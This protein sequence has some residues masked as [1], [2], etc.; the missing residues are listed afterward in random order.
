MN[1]FQTF[2]KKVIP[3]STS[4]FFVFVFS[5]IFQIINEPKEIFGIPL[6]PIYHLKGFIMDLMM[7]LIISS[8]GMLL[9]LLLRI[10]IRK[11]NLFPFHLISIL[12]ILINYTLTVYF[13]Q[14]N[15]L[16]GDAFYQLT[17]SELIISANLDSNLTFLSVS[18][19]LL[20]II[21]YFLIA[22]L[23]KKFR[24]R[25]Y[26]F[27]VFFLLMISSLIAY[28]WKLIQSEDYVGDRVINNKLLA[29]VDVSEKH[30]FAKN[31]TESINSK[32]FRE[33]DDSFFPDPSTRNN[34]YSLIHEL[35]AESEF[36]NFIH[37]SPKGPPNIVIIIVESLS[38]FLVK[39]SAKNPCNVMPF[40]DSLSSKSLYF[41][42][43]ISSCERTHNV[44]PAILASSPN[45]PEKQFM[46]TEELPRHWSLISLL[47]NYHS[48]FYCGVD[49]SF[50]NMRDFM[51]YNQTDYTVNSWEP[52]FSK[53]RDG[54]K[55]FWGYSD[56][57]L[58]EKSI[59][60]DKKHQNKNPKLDVFLTISTH[61]PYSYPNKDKY[62]LLLK[63]KMSKIKC[64]PAQKAAIHHHSELLG[65]YLF[66]DEALKN[67]F[68]K[69]SKKPDFDN[70]IFFILGDHG[71]SLLCETE[72]QR[73]QTP[74]LIYSPLLKK[75]EQFNAISSHNDL[76]P[77]IINYLRVTYPEL[78]LPKQVPFFG[79]EL[80]FEKSFKCERTL[81]LVSLDSETKHL[82]LNNYMQFEGQLFKI[83]K[84]LKLVRIKN[85]QI[86]EKMTKQLSVYQK[87]AR[88]YHEYDKILPNEQYKQFAR[89]GKKIKLSYAPVDEIDKGSK[90]DFIDLGQAI[91]IQ[92][93]W[94]RLEIQLEGEIFLTD[95]DDLKEYAY[96]NFTIEQIHPKKIVLWG[97]HTAKYQ[98]P[99]RLKKWN[100]IKYSLFIDTRK[101]SS[102]GELFRVIYYLHNPKLKNIKIRKNSLEGTA[103]E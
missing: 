50:V 56:D 20:L 3:Y 70:T 80:S 69:A 22:K 12:S 51:D 30:F 28:P 32:T 23:I 10:I 91:N 39:E 33:L 5:R 63:E 13:V 35:K 93:K 41:P 49:L 29:F 14:T 67:Y 79:K 68:K 8:I 90:K 94:K 48:R 25:K 103:W 62:L 99:P 15:Q 81:P 24:L 46:Q 7:T 101:F 2:I 60:D 66:T 76:T 34:E 52:R 84:D 18:F 26:V 43:F 57:H 9:I 82:I 86:N 11:T 19:P 38:T 42:N 74:L 44:L 37:K 61:E 72:I 98:D 4:L 77:T 75:S 21:C 96:I 65:S 102:K 89:H 40:M 83:N 64:S 85:K 36:A 54:V 1:Q 47:K 16:L 27:V 97:S 88:Y 95:Y 55:S 100:K 59:L 71:N 45:P 53:V 58:F 87:L 92:K 17:N 78:K 73:Y 31:E 6:K